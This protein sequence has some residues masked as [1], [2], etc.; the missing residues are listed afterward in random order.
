MAVIL[1]TK[2]DPFSYEELVR[3]AMEMT[4][5]HQEVEQGLAELEAQA[6]E[7]ETKANRETDPIAHSRYMNYARDLKMQ[8]HNLATRGLN[9]QSRKQLYNMSSRY[10]QDIKPISEAFEQR[11]VQALMQQQ[12]KGQDSTMMFDRDAG[13]TSLDEYLANPSLSYRNFSGATLQAMATAAAT[14]LAQ[15]LKSFGKTGSVDAYTDIITAKYGLTSEEVALAIADPTDP[16]ANKALTAIINEVLDASGIKSWNNPAALEEAMGYINNGLYHAIGTNVPNL[17]EN[18]GARKKKEFEYQMASQNDQQ[19]HELLKQSRDHAHQ[20]KMAGLSGKGKGAGSDGEEYPYN[21]AVGKFISLKDQEESKEQWEHA[22]KNGYVEVDKEG[23]VIGITDKGRDFY[24]NTKVIAADKDVQWGSYTSEEQKKHNKE[25]PGSVTGYVKVIENSKSRADKIGKQKYGEPFNALS[26]DPKWYNFMNNLAKKKSGDDNAIAWYGED[27]FIMGEYGIEQ[28]NNLVKGAWGN[29]ETGNTDLLGNKA[30]TTNVTDTNTD[31]LMKDVASNTADSKITT[32][33][34]TNQGKWT[35][36]DYI[37][38]DKLNNYVP[39][40]IVTLKNDPYQPMLQLYAM[41]ED[42]DKK[43][44]DH[45]TAPI[46][47]PL[48]SI[49]SHYENYRNMLANYFTNVQVI[50]DYDTQI[51]NTGKYDGNIANYTQA[52]LNTNIYNPYNILY[53]GEQEFKKALSSV[54][55]KEIKD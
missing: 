29:P 50:D 4:L 28:M 40:R 17:Q 7:W 54:T 18:W 42:G 27:P 36:D 11:R 13:S 9:A 39:E 19:A 34:N 51:A 3:P 12:Q 55:G 15:E 5:A 26:Y 33:T 20:E 21:S 53:L 6:A 46:Y 43:V 52:R 23:N 31:R 22:K 38:K 30:I 10:N 1:N 32:Y 8:A 2:F 48:P 45:E 44:P 35:I 47:V 16:R 41:K 14:K 24:R 25:H 37:G 49:D